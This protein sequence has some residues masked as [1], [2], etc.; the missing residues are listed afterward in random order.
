MVATEN[1]MLM[2]IA[3]EISARESVLGFQEIKTKSRSA[4]LTA[5]FDIASVFFS[6]GCN[7][8]AAFDR[9]SS[10]WSDHSDHVDYAVQIADFGASMLAYTV[11]RGQFDIAVRDIRDIK[12]EV[13]IP[14]L[15]QDPII[16]PYQIHEARVMGIDALQLPVWAM[17]QARLESLV[18]RTESL[19]M[20]AIVSVR[21][22]EE[23]HRAIDAGAS[24]V[25]IDVTGYTGELSLAEAFSGICQFIPQE[26][27]RIALGGCATPKE[28]MKF[29]RFS[30]DAIFVPH[31]D[32]SITKS[33]VTA[34]MHPACP[35][36]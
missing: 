5:A 17:G 1:R 16:D 13:D 34:G 18:D 14:I 29:A 25:A 11:R 19:G 22:H 6:S 20:T 26:I 33:L 15:L 9:F 32:L 10:N 23:A 12:S 8:V 28:L 27:A 7:V 30:A 24:V 36:R 4:G 31:S 2:E 3:A 21:N 35:S